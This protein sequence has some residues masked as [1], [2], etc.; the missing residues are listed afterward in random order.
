MQTLG[1]LEVVLR[2]QRFVIED[3]LVGSKCQE[4][5]FLARSFSDYDQ[6]RQ[7]S[8]NLDCSSLG[9]PSPGVNLSRLHLRSPHTPP[10]R[11]GGFLRR[12]SHGG[13]HTTPLSNAARSNSKLSPSVTPRTSAEAGGHAVA[14]H[15]DEEDDDMHSACSDTFDVSHSQLGSV[16]DLPDQGTPD[17]T[18]DLGPEVPSVLPLNTLVW[19]HCPL[20][21]SSFDRTMSTACSR[22]RVYRMPKREAPVLLLIQ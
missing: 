21:L 8:V 20:I 9:A 4:L 3:R 19:P 12:V 7:N 16:S 18:R 17:A 2:L 11:R 15:V 14:E 13:S 1:H 5:A 22:T 6:D 10:P